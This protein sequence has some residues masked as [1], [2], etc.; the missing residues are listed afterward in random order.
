M[1][2]IKKSPANEQ[3]R[4]IRP[5]EWDELAQHS[6]ILSFGSG[7]QWRGW[8]AEV[9]LLTWRQVKATKGKWGVDGM[10]VDDFPEFQREK[11]WV[12]IRYP[13]GPKRVKTV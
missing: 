7:G 13:D 1:K 12:S 11:Q 9:S 3:K 8:V 10:E 5:T 6:E 2:R 4:H